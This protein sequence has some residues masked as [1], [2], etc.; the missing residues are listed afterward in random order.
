MIV[1]DKGVNE[2][3]HGLWYTKSIFEFACGL[4]LKILDTIVG[5]VADCS[6][7]ESRNFR[8][9]DIL[10]QCKFLLKNYEG[11]ACDFFSWSR[12]DDLQRIYDD[13]VA[14]SGPC[15]RHQGMGSIL[16]CTDETISG[17]TLTPDDRF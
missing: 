9:L 4:W 7:G 6:S 1:D 17:N 14:E 11:V 16:T 8:Y 13:A 15:N 2:H 5:D 12:L 3:E 10:V